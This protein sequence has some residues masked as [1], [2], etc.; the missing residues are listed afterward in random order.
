MGLPINFGNPQSRGLPIELNGG[1]KT[2]PRPTTAIAKVRI[3]A[4][5]A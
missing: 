2:S 3:E 5:I 4:A 1:N